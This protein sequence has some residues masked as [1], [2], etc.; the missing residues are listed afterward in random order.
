MAIDTWLISVYQSFTL[1][2]CYKKLC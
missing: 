2:R 1:G